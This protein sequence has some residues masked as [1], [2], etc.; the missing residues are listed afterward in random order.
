[1]QQ[2]IAD[3]GL[4]KVITEDCGLLPHE[5]LAQAVKYQWHRLKAGSPQNSGASLEKI[6]VSVVSELSQKYNPEIVNEVVTRVGER[7]KEARVWSYVP[8][9]LKKNASQQLVDR[10]G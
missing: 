6:M 5:E 3:E 2:T 1:M 7:F 8:I 10:L 4:E 9:L